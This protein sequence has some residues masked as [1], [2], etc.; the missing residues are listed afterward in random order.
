VRTLA[1]LCV[2]LITNYTI[3]RATDYYFSNTGNDANTGTSETAPWK[4]V[5]KM[6]SII[7]T[8]QPGDRILFERG[9]IWYEVQLAFSNLNGTVSNPIVFGAYGTGNRP[10]FS[11]GK[12]MTELSKSGNIYS[13]SV[14]LQFPHG[15]VSVP[16]GIL[17]DNQWPDIARSSEFFTKGSNSNSY[18][19]DENQSWNPG[20]LEG[21]ILLIQPVR[22]SWSASPIQSNT[23]NELTVYPMKYSVGSNHYAGYYIANKDEYLNTNGEWTFNKKTLKIYHESDLAGKT[24][25]FAVVDSIIGGLN[26]SNLVFRD[27]TFQMANYRLVSFKFGKNITIDG[28]DFGFTAGTAL[29]FYRTENTEIVNNYIHD[30]GAMGVYT[31]QCSNPVIRYNLFKYIAAKHVGMC[32]YKF[33]MSAAVSNATPF[34]DH[35]YV[36][37]NYFDSVGLAIQSHTFLPGRTC[38]YSYNYI[39][40]Y[41][42]TI[43]D[44]AAVYFA[45]DY[46]ATVKTAKKNIIRDAISSG[47]RYT[48]YGDD[49]I[50][51]HPDLH[52][53]AFYVDDGG[54]GYH[55]DSNSIINTSFAFYTNRSHS[56][57]FNYCNVVNADLYNS[58]TYNAVYLKDQAIGS[59]TSSAD[60]DEVK[61]NNIVL[62]SSNSVVYLRH[63]SQYVSSLTD[64]NYFSFDYNKISHPD[65]KSFN[66]G[67]YAYNWGA[68]KNEYSLEDMR[69]NS[70]NV[71]SN[72][73]DEHTVL[74]PQSTMFQDVSD[75]V[76]EE[77]FVK[78]FTNFSKQPKQFNLGEAVF[79]DM[80]GNLVSGSVIVSPFYSKILFYVSGDIATVDEDNYID[81]SLI[82]AFEF[83]ELTGNSSALNYAPSIQAA[84]YNISKS[85]TPSTIIGKL[86][87]SDPDPGQTLSYSIIQGNNDGYFSVSA[88]GELTLLSAVSL[89]ENY[90]FKLTIRVTDNGSPAK[91][92]SAIIQVN[93]IHESGTIVNKSPSILP[94]S[95]NANYDM[96]LPTV[97]GIVEAKDPDDGQQLTYS[98]T[99][100][101]SNNY[102]SIE[103]KTGELSIQSFPSNLVPSTFNL[104]VEVEDNGLNKLK[105]EANITVF[106][107]ASK[108]VFYI[109]P[110]K[111]A[112]SQEDGT[113]E[114]PFHSWSQVTWEED[115][116]YLQKRGT[117]ADADKLLIQEDNVTIGDYGSGPKPVI[118]SMAS[119]YAIKAFDKKNITIKNLQIRAESAIG[120][121]YF[122][123]EQCENNSVEN[124]E[125]EGADYGLRIIDGTSYTVKY[126]VFSNKVDGIYSIAE[127]AE[128][129][130]NVFKGNHKAI[131]ISS[132]SSD[133]KIYNNVFYDNRQGISASYAEVSLYNNI[134]Y[135]TRAGDQALYHKLDKILSNHNIFYPEQSGFVEISEVRYDNM[136]D[137][138]K[139]L[140][141]DMNSFARDPEFMDIYSDNFSVTENSY[142]IDAGKLVG[143]TQDFYGKT[144]PYGGAPDIGL[145]EAIPG[146]LTA[147]EYF[148]T[149]PETKITV[150]PNP[151]SGIFNLILDN[152]DKNITEIRIL[153]LSGS[154]VFKDS[155]ESFGNLLLEIDISN[156]PTGIYILSVKTG[157][158]LYTEKLI[159]E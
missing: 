14:D 70:D 128:V 152:V 55:C 57:T 52:P 27:L 150:Y 129:F 139:E 69:N 47:F 156:Y 26:S 78:L 28:C 158:K 24:V 91:S 136:D 96:S 108:K 77:E 33:R 39:Q 38:S 118:N 141:L 101:N 126:N 149:E 111:S 65:K 121:V 9:S 35:S 153:T 132:Y 72:T 79:R 154:N 123:G 32:N 94:Q 116:S 45:S 3:S 20:E 100:G 80:D 120:C 30:C 16:S 134:F 125:L 138:Q 103:R 61:Y 43:S 88:S 112:D 66:I 29:K 41:G 31:T 44:C 36:E 133:A 5:N 130:Y 21:C 15:E 99:S 62:K 51:P 82:P 23:S 11:G 124:C 140:G 87:A 19:K 113:Y 60:R 37:Y 49:A 147:I 109:D 105:A 18:L 48:S 46:D 107:L 83:V 12:K 76:S 102:F 106:L 7:Q 22:W 10:I 97:I 81:K 6:Q 64:N 84:S 98:I 54:Y 50:N 119:D 145:S 90:T 86:N 110:D 1:V 159:I 92:T 127:S 4:T 2:V 146:Q 144:V 58:S 143:L 89:N 71:N 131:N 115:A 157:N 40:N 53:H 8:L 93:Y 151:S 142:A 17:I 74:N 104:I 63:T 155:Y 75:F 56:N 85:T 95:F 148:N 34:S 68:S 42:V 114:Q 67:R 122:I 117:T 73:S 135:L 137:Y 59:T 25:Q 13:A